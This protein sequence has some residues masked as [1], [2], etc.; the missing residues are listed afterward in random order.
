MNQNND[1]RN[2]SQ[3]DDATTQRLRKLKNAH[4]AHPEEQLVSE[5]IINR[6]QQTST[7]AMQDRSFAIYKQLG[8]AASVVL[9]AIISLI[10]IFGTTSNTAHAQV[11]SL[12]SLHSQ[13]ANSNGVLIN[14]VDLLNREIAAQTNRTA[15]ENWSPQYVES[16]CLTNVKGKILAAC[17]YQLGNQVAS[18]VVAEGKDFAIPM[19]ETIILNDITLYKHSLLD[20]ST[21]NMVM[22]NLDNRWLCVMGNASYDELINITAKIKF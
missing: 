15:D 7:N 6:L 19:G 10:L 21:L 18:I 17:S 16:C 5:R 12:Q 2:I 11:V 4:S 22:V 1:Y 20:S 9:A 13:L 14:N 8:V 3:L